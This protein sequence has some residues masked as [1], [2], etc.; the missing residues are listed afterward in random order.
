MRTHAQPGPLTRARLWWHGRR[1]ARA[2][3]GQ[4]D[5]PRAASFESV[6]NARCRMIAHRLER[7]LEKLVEDFA[8][9]NAEQ[10]RVSNMLAQLPEPTPI[11]TVPA[12]AVDATAAA[13]RLNTRAAE[14]KV[15]LTEQLRRLEIE[16]A[17]LE[18]R[19]EARKR[20]AQTQQEVE[21]EFGKACRDIYLAVLKSYA[22]RMLDTH[23]AV[24]NTG[25]EQA[26]KEGMRP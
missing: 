12:T 11:S 6:A 17:G 24:S 23:D 26:K 5:S 20:T 13:I 25:G 21:T 19:I 9:L 22:I 4:G 16:A 8:R 2:G 15:V 10:Q 14:Q 3:L 18:R 1:D 7:G